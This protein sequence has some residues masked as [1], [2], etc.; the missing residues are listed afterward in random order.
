MASI[1]RWKEAGVDLRVYV[2]TVPGIVLGGYRNVFDLQP[3]GPEGVPNGWVDWSFNPGS[4]NKAHVARSVSGGVFTIV[5]NAIPG[6]GSYW[7]GRW[8]TDAIAGRRYRAS[9]QVRKPELYTVSSYYRC[10]IKEYNP[11]TT[12]ELTIGAMEGWT[13]SQWITVNMFT[14]RPP[15]VAGGYTTIRIILSIQGLSTENWGGE[16]RNVELLARDSTM[17]DPGWR[18]ITCDVQSLT[19]RYGR[20]RFTNRYE[21]ASIALQLQNEDG[22]YAY[23]EAH[24]FNFG[25]GRQLKVEATYDGI[26]YP[27][28]YGIVDQIN[29]GLALDGTAVVN[30]NCLDPTTIASNRPTPALPHVSPALPWLSGTRIGFLVDVI[31]YP[32]RLIDAGQWG[33]QRIEGSGRSVRDEI[34]VTADSEG[35]AFFADRA[36][37]WVYKDRSW[38]TLDPKQLN[39]TADF[40]A[41][42]A[43]AQI[44]F[45]E[46]PTLPGAPTICPNEIVTDYGM[47]RV[48]NLVQLSSVNASMQEFEDDESQFDYGPRTYQRMDFVLMGT[49]Q[50]QYDSYIAQRAADIMEGY[51][52]PKLRLNALTYRPDI[53]THD[54]VWTLSVFLNWLVRV[55]Y[56]NAKTGWGWL[57]VTH[58]Q[59]IEHRI[60]PTE[61]EVGLVVDQ[62]IAQLD[63]PVMVQ[64]FWDG[65]AESDKWDIALWS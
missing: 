57:I 36:G 61:W 45:D 3:G 21:A 52:E 65:T 6:S 8:E 51:T 26:T 32:Y 33:T 62:P 15:N 31:G 7:G 27:M 1:E 30:V 16:F 13:D 55:W 43:N 50:A 54:W 58:V 29:D 49:T 4:D 59:S 5:S 40:Q 11:T 35:A 18:D 63:A 60:T 64:A 22:E 14:N 20:E 24:P 42:K 25:P 44:P 56:Q 48:V 46:V 53:D 38:P 2:A 23:K 12:S 28:A 37:Y 34:G 10:W 47:S 17:P 39:V 19:T 41:R 9:F